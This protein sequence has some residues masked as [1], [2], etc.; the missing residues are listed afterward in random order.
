MTDMNKPVAQKAVRLPSACETCPVHN[1]GN[2][3]R[4]GVDMT[5]WDYVVAF[6]RKPNV[7]KEHRL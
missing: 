6:S 1:A 4:L 2:L 7:G 5:D 3:L